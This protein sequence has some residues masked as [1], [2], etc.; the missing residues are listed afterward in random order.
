MGRP[1]EAV[2]EFERTIAAYPE[3]ASGYNNL[4]YLFARR[5]EELDRAEEL[6]DIAMRL[7]PRHNVYYMDT[8]GWIAF[9]QGRLQEAREMLEGS[10]R[11][12]NRSQ[13]SAISES[14]WHMGRVLEES[15]NVAEAEWYFRKAARLSPRGLYGMRSIADLK[16]LGSFDSSPSLESVD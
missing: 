1:S 13:G 15:G 11:R 10:I 4:A 6:V 14:L 8:A 2:E 3:D 5:G 16:R 7:E 12:M 9:Q